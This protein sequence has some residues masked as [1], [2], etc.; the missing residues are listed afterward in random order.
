MTSKQRFVWTVCMVALTALGLGYGA[1]YAQSDR[2]VFE[3]RT[4]TTHDGKL[5]ALNA[6]FRDHTTRLFNKHGITNVGYWTP[7]E[8]PLA[9][10]TL[11]YILAFP[12]RDAAKKS[13]DDFRSDPEWKKVRADSEANGPIVSKIESVFLQPTDYSTLK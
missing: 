11:I 9:G 4:Y 5:D 6:R 10:N 2:R 3:I 8:G 13:W 12:D 7:A 1:G